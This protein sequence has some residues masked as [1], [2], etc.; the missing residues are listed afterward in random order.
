M[1]VYIC[2]YIY[3]YIY[4]YTHIYI[5]MC[6][7][8]LI[9]DMTF[10]YAVRM[11]V[12]H[13]VMSDIHMCSMTHSYSSIRVSWLFL[14]CTMIHSYVYGLFICSV[15][16]YVARNGGFICVTHSYVWHDSLICVPW[17]IHMCTMTHSCVCDDSFIYTW[18]GDGYSE[19]IAKKRGRGCEVGVVVGGASEIITG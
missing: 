14:M 12:V 8:L 15:G 18:Q 1:C 10:S 4:V 16:V 11:C 6:C 9:C 13:E 17:L 7:D 2:I 5:C 19:E 3:L